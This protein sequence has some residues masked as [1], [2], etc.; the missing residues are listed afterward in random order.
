MLDDTEL[1]E[2]LACME[3]SDRY[4]IEAN[5]SN[6]IRAIKTELHNRGHIQY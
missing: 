4:I 3:D 2:I 1:E 5:K 6:I